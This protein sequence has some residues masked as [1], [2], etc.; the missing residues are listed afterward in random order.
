M[1]KIPTPV[2]PVD[3]A[4]NTSTVLGPMSEQSTVQM[5]LQNEKCFWNDT[6]FSQGD[7]IISDGKCYECSYGRWVEVDD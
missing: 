1:S 5:N 2:K 3:P 6:E 4:R 7:Q